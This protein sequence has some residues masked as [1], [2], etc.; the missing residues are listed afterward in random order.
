MLILPHVP[1]APDGTND[2]GMR[3]LS[4]CFAWTNTVMMTIWQGSVITSTRCS[5]VVI[6]KRPKRR[7]RKTSSGMTKD[8]N[9]DVY[10]IRDAYERLMDIS[11]CATEC[12]KV[13]VI[14]KSNTPPVLKLHLCRNSRPPVL[15]NAWT[16]F[17]FFNADSESKDNCL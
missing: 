2:R 16:V 14:D 12:I 13:T 17:K 3:Y 8:T 5:E 9:D 11:D 6:L 4:D 15:N 7:F 1:H 10:G